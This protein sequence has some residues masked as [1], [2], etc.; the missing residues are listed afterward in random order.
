MS[1]PASKSHYVIHDAAGRIIAS[2]SCPVKDLGLQTAG[3]GRSDLAVLPTGET[4][5][6][7]NASMVQAGTVMPRPALAAT[8]DKIAIKADGLDAA[9]LSTLPAPTRLLVR[10]P[11]GAT[12]HDVTDGQFVLT[13]TWPGTYAIRVLDAWP[14]LPEEWELDAR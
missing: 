4:S 3:W 11:H 13:T 7:P 8:L 14:Y 9:T 12:T 1:E 2:G 5:Y 6:D 10:G